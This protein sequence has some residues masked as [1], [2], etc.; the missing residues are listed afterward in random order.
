MIIYLKED[1]SSPFSISRS[2]AQSCLS[3][4]TESLL[5][6]EKSFLETMHLNICD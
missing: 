1:T 3:Q 5:V 6:V 4:V 2:F